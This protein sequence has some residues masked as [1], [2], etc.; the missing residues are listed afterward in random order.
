MLELAIVGRP[1]FTLGFQLSGVKK[2]F[3]VDNAHEVIQELIEGK[4]D[5][6][7]VV[8]DQAS[9]DDLDRFEQ[10]E[11]EDSIKPV[12]VVMSEEESDKNLQRMIKKSIGVDVWEK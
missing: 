3:N 6:G 5:V 12:F 4:H 7:V 1:E 11:L 2:V 8:I 9:F 10:T